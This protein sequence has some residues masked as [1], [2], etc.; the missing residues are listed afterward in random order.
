MS[1]RQNIKKM[2]VLHIEKAKGFTDQIV[3]LK[4]R[5]HNFLKIF[6]Y[7]LL[8]SCL[9]L[10]VIIYTIKYLQYTEFEKQGWQMYKEPVMTIDKK[11]GGGQEKI[12]LSQE[13]KEPGYWPEY[14]QLIA[15]INEHSVIAIM[16]EH[17]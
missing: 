11:D 15:I 16:N 13:T 7:N 2:Q 14:T 5:V 6:I 8:S 17:K 4:K 12:Y 3:L 10:G 9:G 1:V